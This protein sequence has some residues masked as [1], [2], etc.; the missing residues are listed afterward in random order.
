AEQ[1]QQAVSFFGSGEQDVVVRKVANGEPVKRRAPMASG[2]R[3]A[4]V[5][6]APVPR[7][8][9]SGNFRPY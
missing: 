5:A 3:M 7:A 8:A 2:L 4:A 6:G 9:P 1:L